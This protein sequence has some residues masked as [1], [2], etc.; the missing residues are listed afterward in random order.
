MQNDIAIDFLNFNGKPYAKLFSPIFTKQQLIQQQ[1][2][3]T[4]NGKAQKYIKKLMIGSIKNRINLIKYFGKYR[5][6]TDPEFAQAFESKISRMKMLQKQIKELKEKDLN[7]LK[8]KIFILE[9]QAAQA[10]WYMYEKI[11]DEYIHFPGRK[12]QGA[13]DTVNVMLNY[14]YGILY[15]RIWR[16]VI[17]AKLSPFIGFLH[18]DKRNAA[19]FI[20]DFIEEFRQQAVDR[21]VASMISKREKMEI[22]EG[23]FK[24]DTKALLAQNI[25]GRLND[26]EIF[27]KK[28]MRLE[29]IIQHQAEDFARFLNDEIKTYKPYISKW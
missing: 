23:R 4:T 9:A 17:K 16:A 13:E 11:L 10:Y 12:T 7:L 24:G 15:A 25:T 28:R 20:F 19:A 18:S 2:L 21:V 3:A 22:K 8:E 26:F 27:R 14:G 5:N 6:T 1:A 29:D